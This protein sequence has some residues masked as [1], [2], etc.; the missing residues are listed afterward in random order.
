[1]QVDADQVLAREQRL[2]RVGRRLGL[3]EQADVDRDGEATIR[4]ITNERPL[5]MTGETGWDETSRR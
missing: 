2:R 3:V 1:V 4:M 5:L